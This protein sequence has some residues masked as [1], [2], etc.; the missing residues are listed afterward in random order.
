MTS[1]S[2]IPRPQPRLSPADYVVFGGIA[3]LL[4]ANLIGLVF[5]GDGFNPFVDGWLAV[6]SVW[7][8]VV[9]VWLAVNRVRYAER[10]S[11]PVA[12]ALVHL[13]VTL[14]AALRS[15][16]ATDRYALAILLDRRRWGDLPHATNTAASPIGPA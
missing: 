6:L 11:T 9:L 16:R 2:T 10:H 12:A 5:H 1:V 13:A 3:V 7:V 4:L 8:A 14:H 15:H